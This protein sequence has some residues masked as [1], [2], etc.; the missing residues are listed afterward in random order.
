[1]DDDPGADEGTLTRVSRRGEHRALAAGLRL[2]SRVRWRL[3]RGEDATGGRAKPPFSPTPSN[4]CSPRST[5]MAGARGAR[6]RAPAS[7]SPSGRR[8]AH[9]R[10]GLR[11]Q[12]APPGSWLKRDWRL[13]PRYRIVS[14]SAPRH[15]RTSSRRF[16]S[17][18]MRPARGRV[19]AERGG[20]G[21]GAGGARDA[22]GAAVLR[23]IRV[24]SLI[25]VAG[26]SPRPRVGR[27]ASGGRASRGRGPRARRWT[28]RAPSRVVG[29]VGRILDHE[30]DERTSASA[31]RSS[32]EAG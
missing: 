23:L 32:P 9:G 11:H 19:R 24:V 18:T 17:G 29:I 6:V 22:Q 16:S 8:P 30:H 2:D 15:A 5:S 27:G 3:G 28:S 13:T 7:E 12:D 10:S 14:T 21:R 1:V 25:A 4:P 20:A 26:V 31:R